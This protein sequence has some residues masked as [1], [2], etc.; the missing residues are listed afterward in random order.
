MFVCINAHAFMY[1]CMCVCVYVCVCMYLCVCLCV[2]VCGVCLLTLS[3]DNMHM[4][5][6]TIGPTTSEDAQISGLI[7]TV[8]LSASQTAR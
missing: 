3:L 4:Q 1:I 2:C 6:A 5:I 8:C 7:E